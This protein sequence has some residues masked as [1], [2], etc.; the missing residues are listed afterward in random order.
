MDRKFFLLGPDYF[1]TLFA[2]QDGEGFAKAL[3]VGLMAG[4]TYV[5]PTK[6]LQDTA[7]AAS[8]LVLL[9]TVTGIM[10]V[11]IEKKP[12]TSQSFARVIAKAFAYLSVC[13]V[14]AIVERTIFKGS[15]LSISMGILWL[16]IATEGIS[17]IENVERISGGRFRWLRALLGKVIDQDK[18]AARKEK[19][20]RV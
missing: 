18:E 19:D 15:G 14:A 9:D 16:I 6:D 13:A 4:A 8:I 2:F 11:F 5:F 17:V 3:I 20:D 10:A 12:R 1:R 7:V